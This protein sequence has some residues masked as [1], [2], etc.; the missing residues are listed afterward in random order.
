M[1]RCR[2]L[3]GNGKFLLPSRTHLGAARSLVLNHH[4][5]LDS[6]HSYKTERVV[7]CEG[8]LQHGGGG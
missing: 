2:A 7:L 1:G 5:L 8:C 6:P 3:W 4:W